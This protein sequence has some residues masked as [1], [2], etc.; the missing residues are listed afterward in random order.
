[1]KEGSK[2][3]RSGEEA[4]RKDLFL[5]HVL[6]F[7][8]QDTGRSISREQIKALLMVTDFSNFVCR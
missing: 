2:L 6:E 1:M 7:K 8:E 4:K 3:A 5:H